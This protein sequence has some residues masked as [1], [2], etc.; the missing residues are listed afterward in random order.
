MDQLVMAKTGARLG[1]MECGA[2]WS[3]QLSCPLRHLGKFL[4]GFQFCRGTQSG[5]PSTPLN[6]RLVIAER[7]RLFARVKSHEPVEWEQVMRSANALGM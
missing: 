5:F 1:V 4:L 2:I 7:N 6:L 3:S